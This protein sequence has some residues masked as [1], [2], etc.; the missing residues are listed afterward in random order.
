MHAISR[1]EHSSHQLLNDPMLDPERRPSL[2][3]ALDPSSLVPRPSS[4]TPHPFIGRPPPP[5]PP[6]PCPR[7]SIRHGSHLSLSLSLSLNP[8]THRWLLLP[9]PLTPEP[10]RALPLLPPLPPPPPDHPPRLAGSLSCIRDRLRLDT[11]TLGYLSPPSSHRPS[12]GPQRRHPRQLPARLRTTTVTD[13]LSC[14]PER[15]FLDSPLIVNSSLP[16]SFLDTSTAGSCT[17]SA[18]DRLLH[19]R[20]L[21]LQLPTPPSHHITIRYIIPLGLNRSATE[22]QVV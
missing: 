15:V 5:P 10:R 14:F 17:F 22:E 4:L 2:P 12:P 9:L 3:P 7:P 20:H 19:H 16:Q 18:L 6:S 11:T 1:A 21:L 13:D 8:T